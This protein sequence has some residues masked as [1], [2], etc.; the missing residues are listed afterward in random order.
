MNSAPE[1][2]H[3]WYYNQ[4]VW[5]KT[6][7]L[8]V[9]CLKSVSDMWNYQEILADLKPAAV[10]EFGTN[11]GGS[12]LYFAEMLRIIHGGGH[13][14]TIDIDHSRVHERARQN[15][16]IDFFEADTISPLVAERIRE[17]RSKFPGRAFFIVDSDHSMK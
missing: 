6:T 5:T 13:V 4:P 15:K 2:Y 8:G 9:P 1:Q 16:N 14:L 17:V 3:L 11:E 12:A 10:I 7:F